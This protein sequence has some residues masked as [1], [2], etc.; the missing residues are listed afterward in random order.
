[1]KRAGGRRSKGDGENLL[2]EK[3]GYF[4]MEVTEM[5]DRNGK[6]RIPVTKKRKKR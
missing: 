5:M 2:M 4:H 1:V 3:A 6:C